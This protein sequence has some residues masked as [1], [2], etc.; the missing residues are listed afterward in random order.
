LIPFAKTKIHQNGVI[1][2]SRT[3]AEVKAA[4]NALYNRL[5][6]SYAEK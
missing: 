5:S 4:L 6:E 2:D 3:S 1:T